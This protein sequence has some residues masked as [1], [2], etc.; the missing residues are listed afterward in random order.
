M[1]RILFVDDDANVL[2]GLRCM[3]RRMK[4]EWDM[5][6][7]DSGEKALAAMEKDPFDVIVSDMRMPGMDGA[8]LLAQVRDKYPKTVRIVLSGHSEKE[9]IMRSVGPAHQYLSKPCDAEQLRLTVSRALGLR[10]LVH[11]PELKA[12]VAR[13]D[14]LPS[15][16]DLYTKIM[17]ELDSPN[18]SIKRIGE[19]ISQDLG[20]TAKILQLVNSSFFG[21][22]RHIADA[23]QAVNFLG[24]EIIKSLVLSIQVFSQ[25][26]S[27]QLK[28]IQ[29]DVLWQHSMTVGMLSRD[30]ALQQELSKSEADDSFMGGVLHDVGKLVLAANLPEQYAEVMKA[31]NAKK[32]RQEDLETEV[33][34]A[35]HSQIGAYLLGLWG[36]TDPLLEAIAFHHNP[37][38]SKVHGFAP[39]ASV[40]IANGLQYVSTLGEAEHSDQISIS[41]LD[42]LNVLENLQGWI[43]EAKSSE[44]RGDV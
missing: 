33:F 21:L 12:L 13:L 43:E 11:N 7:A 27:E 37:E 30:L 39:L 1:M 34:G 29:P 42:H 20:M 31:V 16:P 15:L 8:D 17:E 28:A 41:Y 35:S 2:A 40:H 36:G 4:K 38:A 32:G 6:F 23:T 19:I 26:K 3:L 5:H 9:M 14:T 24:V 10:T 25:M 18:A 44:N 22:R